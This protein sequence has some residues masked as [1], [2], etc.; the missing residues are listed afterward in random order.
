MIIV[1]NEYHV[2]DLTYV[3]LPK[4]KTLDDIKYIGC[5]WGI[6]YIEFKDGTEMDGIEMD[7][8]GEISGE[9]FKRPDVIKVTDEDFENE[10]VF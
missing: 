9:D 3:E 10:I 6:G 1:K 2:E 7:G 8:I 4:G 5:K